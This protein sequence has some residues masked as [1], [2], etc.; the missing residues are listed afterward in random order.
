ML[1]SL[2]SVGSDGKFSPVWRTAAAVSSQEDSIDRIFIRDIIA[3][4]G[5]I[6]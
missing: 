1:R 2:K 3:F 4:F 5:G 6:G